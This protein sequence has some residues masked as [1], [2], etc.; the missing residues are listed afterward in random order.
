[1]AIDLLITNK[2]Y[3]LDDVIGRAF[4]RELYGVTFDWIALPHP[5][6]LN[7]WNNT[8]SGKALTGKALALLKRHPVMKELI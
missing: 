7:V 5:S 2:K 1:M 8:P 4:Q 3:K 6:G